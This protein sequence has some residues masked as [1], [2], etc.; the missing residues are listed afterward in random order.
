MKTKRDRSRSLHSFVR[1]F[2]LLFCAIGLV[3][4][5]YSASQKAGH[6]QT[7]S[8][9]RALTHQD[10]DSWRSV[11]GSQI[12]NDGKFVAYALIPQDGD[13][14]IVVRDLARSEWRYPRGWRPPQPPPDLSDPTV[15]TNFLTTMSRI[16]RPFFT[17]DSRYLIFTIEPNKADVLKAR[18]EK[19]KPEEMPQN[20]L[21]IMDLSSGQGGQ[22]TRIER[23]KS[24]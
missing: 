13:G 22:V 3:S 11:Q 9:K 23:V 17:A 15:A 6:A 8:A 24:F 16:S 12:S 18:K 19:K 21:G 1:N 10:Y 7:V 2:L 4:L 5:T 14:E 20:A